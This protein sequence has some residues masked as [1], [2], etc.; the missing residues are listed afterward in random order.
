MTKEAVLFL[1]VKGKEKPEKETAT[2][3]LEYYR[4]SLCCI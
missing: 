3:G 1:Q 4:Y 2:V